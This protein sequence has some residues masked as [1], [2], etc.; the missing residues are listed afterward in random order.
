MSLPGLPEK[1]AFLSQPD[2]YPEVTDSVER[3]ETHMDWVFLA[4]RHAWK[5]K[6]PVRHPFLDFGTMEARRADCHL[7]I[8]LNRRLARG[9]YESVCALSVDR[10]GEL[11][12]ESGNGEIVD[13]LVKMRRL[14][15]DRMLDRLIADGR[16]EAAECHQVGVL[17]GEFYR[18]AEPDSFGPLSYW[19]RLEREVS[20]NEAELSRPEFGLGRERVARVAANL[21]KFLQ[22]HGDWVDRRVRAG[23]IVDGHGDL[24]PEHV[25]LDESPLII[26]CIEFNREFRIQDAAQDLAFLLLECHRLGADGIGRH[27]WEGYVGASGDD[28]PESLLHYYKCHQALTR[29]K[30]GLWHLD[31][32]TISG[33][34]RWKARALHYLDLIESGAMAGVG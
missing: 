13:W 23:R 5:L 33:P 9:V 25:C 28:C 12:L 20:V 26:D 15:R 4:G 18:N 6:K 7:E 22:L 29:A 2:S 34:D 17:L 30:V 31:D 16:A 19:N 24:R 1:V 10:A 3:I 27:I 32:Q 21:R 11:H 14:P 8:A